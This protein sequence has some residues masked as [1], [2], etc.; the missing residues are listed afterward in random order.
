MRF[1]I[2]YLWCLCVD[3]Q[4]ASLC[5]FEISGL[6]GIGPVVACNGVYVPDKSGSGHNGH[7]VFAH[8]RGHRFVYYDDLGDWMIAHSRSD[9]SRNE[10]IAST[11]VDGFFSPVVASRSGWL[12]DDGTALV[13]CSAGV[14][15]VA[16]SGEWYL[17]AG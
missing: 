10:G 1:P 5:G 16:I 6:E 11:A 3:G 12:V 9:F 14:T 8:V 13:P 2:L 4:A 17:F 7:P 15:V